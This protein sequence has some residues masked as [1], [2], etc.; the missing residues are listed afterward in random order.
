[1]SSGVNRS[2]DNISDFSLNVTM[3]QFVFSVSDKY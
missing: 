3:V 2:G 1:M